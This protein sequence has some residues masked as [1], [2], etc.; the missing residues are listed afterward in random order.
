MTLFKPKEEEVMNRRSILSVS[1]ITVLGFAILPTSAAFAQQKSL[2]DQ[3]IGS[4]MLVSSETIAANGTK[5]QLYGPN[6]RGILI[7]DAGGRY[8]TAQARPNRPKPKS[9]SR[10]QVT[11]AEL[12]A[13]AREF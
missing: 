8:A 4:W 3:L 5:Q 11:D 7:F 12:G 1:A 9:A 6:P 2:K 10:F 13:A